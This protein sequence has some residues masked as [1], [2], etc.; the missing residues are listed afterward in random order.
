[1]LQN[2]RP[3][4]NAL[5]AGLAATAIGLFSASAASAGGIVSDWLF[6]NDVAFTAFAPAPIGSQG[7]FGSN[8]NPTLMAPSRLDWNTAGPTG[9]SV[10]AVGEDGFLGAGG[11]NSGNGSSGSVAVSTGTPMAPGAFTASVDFVHSNNQV[12]FPESTWL[13]SYTIKDRLTLTVDDGGIHDGDTFALPDIDFDGYF[14]ETVNAGVDADMDP[15]T[16]NTCDPVSVGSPLCADIF[17]IIPPIDPDIMIDIDA[18]TGEITITQMFTFWDQ[19]YNVDIRL[20]G[21]TLL[22]DDSCDAAL[23]AGHPVADANLGCIGVITTEGADNIFS[24]SLRIH[25]KD[26]P[27]VVQVVEPGTLGLLGFSLA[28]LGLAQRRRRKS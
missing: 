23:P 28:A 7:V 27:P 18:G 22:T 21:L 1:M 2:L 11:L 5:R 19:G 16:P 17:V 13:M 4:G 24:A 6:V 12:P 10:L 9:T 15:M 14:R 3:T 8:D 25:A 20:D 26:G